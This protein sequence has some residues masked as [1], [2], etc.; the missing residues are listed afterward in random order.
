ME[1]KPT[2][3]ETLAIEHDKSFA[4]QVAAERRRQLFDQQVKGA[5]IDETMRNAW[6][7]LHAAPAG[8][9]P[10]ADD[11]IRR[12]LAEQA[13]HQSSASP[14]APNPTPPAAGTPHQQALSWQKLAPLLGIA[15]FGDPLLTGRQVDQRE[16]EKEAI[17]DLIDRILKNR[18]EPLF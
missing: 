8:A 16:L 15:P 7:A 14:I 17:G 1:R 10:N 13:E 12:K 4:R 3:E 2:F 9:F 18:F 11:H 5:T 6:D